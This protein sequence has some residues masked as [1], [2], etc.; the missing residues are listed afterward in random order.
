MATTAVKPEAKRR[1]RNGESTVIGVDLKE[2]PEV[3][4]KIRAEA[5]AD[6]REPSKYLRRVIV[7]HYTAKQGE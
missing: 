5:K 1:A 3:L 6:D 4:A 2:F 7:K